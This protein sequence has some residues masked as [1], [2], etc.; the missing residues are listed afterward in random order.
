MNTAINRLKRRETWA[1]CGIL[2][3]RQVHDLIADLPRFSRTVISPQFDHEKTACPEP[4]C[5]FIL[6]PA[7]ATS[8]FGFAFARTK[9]S[10]VDRNGIFREGRDLGRAAGPSAT[11]CRSGA[12]W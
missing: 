8:R 11:R 2:S 6:S 7:V 3:S 1:S 9:R 4:S 5:R 10:I 12:A